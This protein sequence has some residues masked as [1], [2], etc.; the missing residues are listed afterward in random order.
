MMVK[1]EPCLAEEF[2]ENPNKKDVRVLLQKYREDIVRNVSC[3]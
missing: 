3:K 2:N 1:T